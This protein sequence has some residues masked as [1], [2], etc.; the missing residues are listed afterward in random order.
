MKHQKH[1]QLDLKIHH[2]CTTSPDSTHSCTDRAPSLRTYLQDPCQKAFQRPIDA[3]NKPRPKASGRGRKGRQAGRKEG[4]GAGTGSEKAVEEG[5][6]D[7]VE[8]TSDGLRVVTLDD[9]G[10]E[11]ESD[12]ALFVVIA[13]EELEAV[14]HGGA[15]QGRGGGRLSVLYV[16]RS[17]TETGN[18]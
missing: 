2:Q 6:A 7:R 8:D 10:G 15:W 9:F 13:P 16:G 11:E 14:V 17:L 12:E 18:G 3:P 4:D 5:E 1:R